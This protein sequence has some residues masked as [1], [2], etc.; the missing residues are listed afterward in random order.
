MC[1]S[2]ANCERALVQLTPP[3]SACAIAVTGNAEPAGAARP[4]GSVDQHT[5][6][7]TPGPRDT[8]TQIDRAALALAKHAPG[9]TRLMFR[10][11]RASRRL[12]PRHPD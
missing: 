6:A 4:A 3:G 9:A 2:L 1:G 5:A 12:R 10:V 8:M 11:R 7:L